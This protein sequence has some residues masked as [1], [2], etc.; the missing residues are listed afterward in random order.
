MRRQRRGSCGKLTRRSR[1]GRY[2]KVFRAPR[3]LFSLYRG[4]SEY[5]SLPGSIHEIRP[6]HVTFAWQF[7]ECSTRRSLP[8]RHR[9]E[10]QSFLLTS[11][12]SSPELTLDQKRIVTD[13]V[14]IPV[15]LPV[16][17]VT[18]YQIE[19]CESMREIIGPSSLPVSVMPFKNII[20]DRKMLSM[21]LKHLSNDKRGLGIR[22]RPANE[23]HVVAIVE[24]ATTAVLGYFHVA[25]CLRFSVVY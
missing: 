24:Y 7:R 19:S 20:D 1:H 18:G 15:Q 11:E 2:S 8:K 4:R 16:Q 3:K 9:N 13:E 6:V 14:A 25:L 5:Y 17:L 23:A 21:S 12:I 22:W 10:H